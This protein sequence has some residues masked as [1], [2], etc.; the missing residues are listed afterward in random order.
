MPRHPAPPPEIL[1]AAEADYRAMCA[2]VATAV[3]G[4]RLLVVGY[5]SPV[6]AFAETYRALRGLDPAV[7]AAMGAAAILQLAT[8]PDHAP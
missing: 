2:S 5:G 4:A 1:A 3:T 6:E 7:A 8:R